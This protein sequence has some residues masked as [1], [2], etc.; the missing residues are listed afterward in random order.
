MSAGG[1][2]ID[3]RAFTGRR[4]QLPVALVA[5]RARGGDLEWILPKGHIEPGESAEQAAVREVQEET[6]IRG[7]VVEP[8]G[9]I[10][11]WFV[12][13][14][15]R[16]HKTVQH[17]VLEAVGGQLSSSDVEVERLEWVPLAEAP[18]RMRY[19]DERD[20]VEQAAERAAEAG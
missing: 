9:T 5:R 1:L 3:R 8:L 7:L 20:L 15:Q 6:G 11:Y 4:D 12:H 18:R 13:T 10:E 14:G 16:V 2:V 17:F 19:S